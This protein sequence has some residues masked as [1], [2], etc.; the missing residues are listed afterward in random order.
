MITQAC[1]ACGTVSSSA[2]PLRFCARCGSPQ[3]P[4]G[5]LDM[6]LASGRSV[7]AAYG[8]WAL[9][10]LGVAGVHRFYCGKYLT[11]VLWLVTWGLLGVGS[12]IDLFLIPGMVDRVNMRGMVRTAW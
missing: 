10:L 1:P 9:C 6:T 3:P 11:G 7:G 12:F 2:S 8:L 5:A 4:M